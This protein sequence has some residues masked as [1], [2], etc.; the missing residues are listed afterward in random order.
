MAWNFR[1]IMDSSNQ[2]G[3]LCICLSGDMWYG[4]N[5]TLPG[6]TEVEW[7]GL[8]CVSGVDGEFAGG[9]YQC[10]RKICQFIM[11]MSMS[12]CNM[13]VY[14]VNVNVNVQYVS[15]SCQFIMLMLQAPTEGHKLT[16]TPQGGSTTHKLA[17]LGEFGGLGGY[18]PE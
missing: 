10:L 15:L 9:K 13:S 6:G 17:E 8:I 1:N 11:S 14:H 12:T 7:K 16:K 3:M 2:L 18:P 4:G 5:C